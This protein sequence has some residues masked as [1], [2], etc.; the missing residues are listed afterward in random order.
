MGNW[1]KQHF[2]LSLSWITIAVH[3]SLEMDQGVEDS[4]IPIQ[5]KC[6]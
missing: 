3:I 2:H 5:I 4:F 1:L 6:H